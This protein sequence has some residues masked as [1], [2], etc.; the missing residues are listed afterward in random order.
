MCVSVAIER[1]DATRNLS[2]GGD[3]IVDVVLVVRLQ[4]SDSQSTRL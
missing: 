2:S 4:V 1:N 3:A